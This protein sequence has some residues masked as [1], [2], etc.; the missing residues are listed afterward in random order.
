[1]ER[2]NGTGAGAAESM[3]GA[4]VDGGGEDGS[5]GG[6]AREQRERVSGGEWMRERERMG[7][8]VRRERETGS[9]M[10]VA[11]AVSGGYGG[12]RGKS[13]MGEVVT[14]RRRRMRGRVAG[15]GGAT[16]GGDEGGCGEGGE[17]DG[18]MGKRMVG[19]KKCATAQCSLRIRLSSF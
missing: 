17:E 9:V 18:G 14:G 1:M 16:V 2:G 19:G 8:G 7:V 12:V 3:R 11:G 13:E 4:A 10:A 6:F 15:G 5:G